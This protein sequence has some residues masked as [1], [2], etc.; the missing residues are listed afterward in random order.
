[1]IYGNSLQRS[2]VAIAF[3]K[4]NTT[5]HLIAADRLLD[6]RQLEIADAFEV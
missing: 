3:G 1:M 4:P 2:M 5:V 6:V